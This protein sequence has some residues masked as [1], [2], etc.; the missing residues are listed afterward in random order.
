MLLQMLVGVGFIGFMTTVRIP[1]KAT[2]ENN[3]NK[4]IKKKKQ[5]AFQSSPLNLCLLQI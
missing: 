3:S 1:S 2:A 4:K 5:F